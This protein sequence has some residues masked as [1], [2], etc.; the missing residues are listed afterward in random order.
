MVSESIASVCSGM[1]QLMSIRALYPGARTTRPD[2]QYKIYP[3]LLRDLVIDRVNQ[4]CCTD[5]T[6][7]G[8]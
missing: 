8:D 4:V 3:C 5:L 7:Y 2:R 6:Y 1:M